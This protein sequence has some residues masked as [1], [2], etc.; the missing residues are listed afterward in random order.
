[1]SHGHKP[2]T[3]EE[4]LLVQERD[5]IYR[6]DSLW[7]VMRTQRERPENKYMNDGKGPFFLVRLGK[8]G[9]GGHEHWS[10]YEQFSLKPCCGE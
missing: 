6:Y 7:T 9:Y 4:A 8:N 5:M 2:M 3:Y 1:M 10:S